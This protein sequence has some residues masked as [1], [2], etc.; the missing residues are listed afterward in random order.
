MYAFISGCGTAEFG[1]PDVPFWT[2]V[3]QANKPGINGGFL[4]M[5]WKPTSLELLGARIE[6]ARL[7]RV[8]VGDVQILSYDDDINKAK[9]RGHVTKP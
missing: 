4:G 8:S 6:I 5:Q 9:A 3:P 7:L 1:A 2:H